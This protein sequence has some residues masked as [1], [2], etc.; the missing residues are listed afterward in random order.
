M[1][2]SSKRNFDDSLAFDIAV[3]AQ[4]ARRADAPAVR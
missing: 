2:M 1:N 4:A 3:T